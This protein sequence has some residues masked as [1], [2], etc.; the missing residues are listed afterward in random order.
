MFWKWSDCIL[1]VSRAPLLNFA[2]EKYLLE[3]PELGGVLDWLDSFNEISIFS[4]HVERSHCL[5]KS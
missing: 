1:V 2:F 5:P 3:I 4:E